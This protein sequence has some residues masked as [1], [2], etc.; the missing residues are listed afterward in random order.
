MRQVLFIVS[1]FGLA[2]TINACKK[3]SDADTNCLPTATTVR[4][5]INKQ[6]TIKLTA[7][8]NPVYLVED[9]AIDTKLIPC[10]FPQEFYE[11]DL[12]VTISGEVK[13]TAQVGPGPC[14]SENFVITSITR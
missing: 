9:G 10:N 12:R 4:Q 3:K 1:L 6:A 11:N 13:A 2:I 8:I 14:C 7:M 5:I